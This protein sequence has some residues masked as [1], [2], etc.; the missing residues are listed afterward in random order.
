MREIIEKELADKPFFLNTKEVGEIINSGHS[1]VNDL[2]NKGLLPAFRFGKV[3][4][5]PK[6]ALIDYIME[7]KVDVIWKLNYNYWLF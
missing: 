7:S 2:I 1:T 4:K 3:F 6:Y 5:I